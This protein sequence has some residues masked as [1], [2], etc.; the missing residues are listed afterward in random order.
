MLRKSNLPSYLALF[1]SVLTSIILTVVIVAIVFNTRGASSNAEVIVKLQEFEWRLGNFQNIRAPTGTANYTQSVNSRPANLRPGWLAQVYPTPRGEIQD[2]TGPDLGTFILDETKFHLQIH[3][4][5][6]IAQPNAAAYRLKAFYVAEKGGRHEFSF[7][8]KYLCAG[9]MKSGSPANCKI[10]LY[11]D[12]RKVIDQVSKLLPP[13][14]SEVLLT[15]RIQL[16][17]GIYVVEAE[18]AC[19]IGKSKG[20]DMFVLIRTRPP[21][22]TSFSQRRDAFLH[23]AS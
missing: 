9:A 8:L 2:L 14:Y 13:N 11:I 6:A 20:R 10:R 7:D 23:E 15:G 3:D 21:G 1:I 16:E 5:H 17:P 19:N 18:I 12:N 4:G 22:A